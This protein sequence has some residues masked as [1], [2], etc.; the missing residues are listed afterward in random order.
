VMA[1][2]RMRLFE[3]GAPERKSPARRPGHHNPDLL[4]Q[5]A[6]LGGFVI[7]LSWTRES[8]RVSFSSSL[9]KANDPR[10][11]GQVSARH[12]RRR[13]GALYDV[14]VSPRLTPMLTST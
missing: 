14:P 3:T 11:G 13:V 12:L 2:T 7:V 6:I 5:G 9:A 8:S 4:C 10:R 1:I